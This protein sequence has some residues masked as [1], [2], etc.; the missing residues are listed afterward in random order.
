MTAATIIILMVLLRNCKAMGVAAALGCAFLSASA[1][2]FESEGLCYNIL[3]ADSHTAAVTCRAD[4]SA[5]SNYVKG[6]LVIPASVVYE[7]QT[8]D[9]VAISDRAFL[10]NGQLKSVVIPESVHQIGA[11]AFRDCNLLAKAN[12]PEGLT[13]VSNDLFMNCYALGNVA[14]PSTVKT[15]GENAFRECQ[16]IT[17]VQIPNSVQTVGNCAF[18]R[19]LALSEVTIGNSVQTIGWYVFSGCVLIDSVYL[20]ASLT[21]MDYTAFFSCEGMTAFEVDPE[22][23]VYA[24]LDGILYDKQFKTVIACPKGFTGKAT[25]P[26]TVE[27][28]SEDAF[29]YCF[30]I[31]AVEMLGDVKYIGDNAFMVCSKL[32]D[33]NIPATV[34]FIGERAFERCESLTSIQLPDALESI[35]FKCFNQCT[36]LTSITIPENVL[37]IGD[38]AFMQCV[39]LMSVKIPD[40][41]RTVGQLVFYGCTKLVI[42]EIGRSVSSIGSATFADCNRLEEVRCY[43]STPAKVASD[44]FDSGQYSK[45]KLYVPEGSLDA[46]NQDLIWKLFRTKIEFEVSNG[47]DNVTTST[48]DRMECARYD[49]T[50]AKVDESYRGVVV[51]VYN[52][53]THVKRINR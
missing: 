11:A 7:S 44:T 40:K 24:S 4:G 27:T 17:K 21:D 18:Q 30:K 14:I 48:G 47:I 46:Y 38:Y 35:S 37:S 32:S 49:M 25:L 16:Q 2:D 50:G 1:Y 10:A 28:I 45:A 5:N 8:Y 36:R 31:T 12:L 43:S 26:E 29:K 3:S 22:N 9:V 51:I 19:C 52:D 53:G 34:N 13:A 42:A 33:I 20:P 6:D 15:I 39:G 41:V 23:P